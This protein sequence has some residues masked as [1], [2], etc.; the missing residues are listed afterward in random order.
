MTI[1]YVKTLCTI[2]KCFTYTTKTTL[3]SITDPL[4][5]PQDELFA[6]T[7]N[8]ISKRVRSKDIKYI[9]KIEIGKTVDDLEI[10]YKEPYKV[11][12]SDKDPYIYEG[13]KPLEY[14][15][16]LI[17]DSLPFHKARMLW[18]DKYIPW[19]HADENHID[20]I[21][22]ILLE[23]ITKPTSAL[24][25]LDLVESLKGILRFKAKPTKPLKGPDG[26]PL[27]SKELS[28][29][30]LHINPFSSRRT[31]TNPD[32][33]VMSQEANIISKTI[34]PLE[35]SH[36]STPNGSGYA[37]FAADR[38]AVS[39]DQEMMDSILNYLNIYYAGDTED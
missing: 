1:R 29:K 39:R 9:R 27:P 20:F 4:K 14:L 13:D 38:I 33:K 8:T 28:T 30:G 19:H 6:D 24:D 12:E 15:R 26:K 22:T 25:F 2:R 3:S 37:S 35:I 32:G 7:I 36:K 21:R 34:P 31:M 23:F 17:F 10:T 16:F 18:D 11:K 5:V